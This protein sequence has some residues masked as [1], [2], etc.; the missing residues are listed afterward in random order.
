MNYFDDK[1]A[2][3]ERSV[4]EERQF[5]QEVGD[6]LMQMQEA[7]ELGGGF[8]AGMSTRGLNNELHRMLE[9]TQMSFDADLAKMLEDTGHGHLNKGSELKFQDPGH[10]GPDIG[11]DGP[12]IGE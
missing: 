5:I 4:F 1:V 8:F 6:P 11:D 10:D 7:Q 2:K 9:N 3:L 12:V